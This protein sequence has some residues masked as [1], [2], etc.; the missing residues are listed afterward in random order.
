MRA[1]ILVG[2]YGTRL[3][4]LTLTTPKPLVPFC[5]KSITLRQL[6]ALRDVGV[7]QVVLAVAY[8]SEVMAEVTQKWA[9]ELG[10]SVVCSLEVE[11][12]GTAGPLA[13]A[14]EYLLQDDK[15][16]FVFNADVICTFP[17]QK[18]LDF[19]LSHGREGTIA[20]TKVK[21]WR[22]YGV[23]VHDEVTGAIKQFV[24]KPPEFV[25]DRI[26]AGIYI[27]NKSIL[28]RIKLEKTSIERQVFP[29]MASDSQL[30]AF[31]LEGFWMDIGVPKDYIE[32]MGKYLDSLAGTS[33]EVGFS[34]DER[35]VSDRSYVLKGCVMIHPT[36][37]I[38]EGSVI[39]PHV[40]IGPGCVIGPCCR[41]QRTAILDNS[42]VGRGTL[43]ES[44]IVGWNGRIGSWC[45]IVNDTVLGE[46]V[47]VDD[48]KY[49]N[50]VKVL[51]NKEITQNHPEP[52]VLM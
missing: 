18:L 8:R 48:G 41:I 16:F 51:P 21:D 36:A 5:N 12:L 28:N 22:K 33:T 24:E 45:R 30:S 1:V 23:V 44:S 46:D 34:C 52:E 47:R 35:R 43:I 37:K 40:S 42:T 10:I 11:P 3:R 17:L 4:P 50:G 7:T 31:H 49:L 29:M 27:F 26:N 19:H 13:L 6:E 15:P 14:R 39:G 9:R 2:G 20:V 32:G 38:G 25:G